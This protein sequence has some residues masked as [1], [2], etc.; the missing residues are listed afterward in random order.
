MSKARYVMANGQS[1]LL[2]KSNW[3]GR[4]GLVLRALSVIQ[5]IGGLGLMV[6][7]GGRSYG[8]SLGLTAL[9]MVLWVVSRPKQ[10][11][12]FSDDG[13]MVTQFWR[14]RKERIIRHAEIHK[15]I[16][17]GSFPEPAP[18]LLLHSGELLALPRLGEVRAAEKSFPVE[19]APWGTAEMYAA[20]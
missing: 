4:A 14:W 18:Y 13:L 9:G 16:I 15:A 7:S 17:D 6:L 19:R 11:W 12:S 3:K 5:I 10:E 20:R 8:E 1:L 2:A